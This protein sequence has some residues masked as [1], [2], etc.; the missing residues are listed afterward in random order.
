[1]GRGGLGRR[2]VVADAA[3]LGYLLERL[4][5][6][7]IQADTVQRVPAVDEPIFVGLS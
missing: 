6:Q 2:G 3:E 7:G 5:D 1:M 4:A